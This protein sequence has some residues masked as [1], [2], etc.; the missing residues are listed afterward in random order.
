M[1]R[2]SA[3]KLETDLEQSQ[4]ELITGEIVMK[5]EGWRSVDGSQEVDTVNSTHNYSQQRA[6]ESR[7]CAHAR[8]ALYTL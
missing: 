1:K 4:H 6:Y 7:R 8:Y 5:D 3:A 2:L